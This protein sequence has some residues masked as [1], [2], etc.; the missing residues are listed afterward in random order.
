PPAPHPSTATVGHEVRTGIE[1]KAPADLVWPHVIAFDPIEEPREM[2]FRTG[3]AYPQY[4]RIDGRGV[5]ATRYCVFS[6]GAFV[7]P[8]THW[9]VS[10]R[11]SFD[12]VSSPA[13]L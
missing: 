7:E 12:V 8:V 4:A 10:R 6:T 11:L 13:P 3:V 2:V 1:I 5:G 9:E